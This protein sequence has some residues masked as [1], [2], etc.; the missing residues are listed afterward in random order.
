MPGEIEFVETS[1]LPGPHVEA[2]AQL[3]CLAFEDFY[4]LFT[5]RQDRL[6]AAVA[7]QFRS[8]SELNQLVA[9]LGGGR[10]VGIGSYY[11]LAEMPAR[12]MAG[13][14]ILFE[15][16]NDPA[17]SATSLRRFSRNFTPPG[18]D[19]AYISRFAISVDKRGSGLAGQLLQEVEKVIRRRELTKVLLHVRRDNERALAFYSKAGYRPE[20]KGDLGYVL[21]GKDL[22]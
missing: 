5:S 12:Q 19:G 14:R 10:V 11:A 4:A 22:G 16:A 21:L 15:A 18:D 20:D 17:L 2:A 1:E 3:A 8:Y 9:V 6:L 7:D 13:A